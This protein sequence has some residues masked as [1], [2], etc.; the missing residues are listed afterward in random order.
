MQTLALFSLYSPT[1]HPRLP[2]TTMSTLPHQLQR[3]PSSVLCSLLPAADGGIYPPTRHSHHPRLFLTTTFFLQ[4]RRRRS[5]VSYSSLPA[6]G[7]DGSGDHD[8]DFQALAEVPKDFNLIPLCKTLFTDEVTPTTAYWRLTKGDDDSY[9]LSFISTLPSGNGRYTLI[10][11]QLAVEF[12]AKKNFVTIIDGWEGSRRK[13]FVDDPMC[14]LKR[15]M[16]KWKPE[17]LVG[18]PDTF[19]GKFPLAFSVMIHDL[20]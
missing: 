20:A 19:C 11:A 12:V 16:E 10:G 7:D 4:L 18:F 15:M 3:R 17:P 8:D 9:S 5:L 2:L 1:P 13:E 6:T 14:L